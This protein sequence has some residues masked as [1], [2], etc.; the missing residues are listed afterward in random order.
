MS[1]SNYFIRWNKGS[2][3]PRWSYQYLDAEHQL[4]IFELSKIP[5]FAEPRFLPLGEKLEERRAEI[6]KRQLNM[7]RMLHPI[8]ENAAISLRL[9]KMG[10]HLQIF[11]I[12]RIRQE[13]MN[14]TNWAERIHNLF[15]REYTLNRITEQSH[16]DLWNKATDLSWSR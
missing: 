5:N 3:E 7:L 13:Q 6:V 4:I 10:D 2:Y 16:P 12:L 8:L 14:D 1:K 15:P 11:V 9:R